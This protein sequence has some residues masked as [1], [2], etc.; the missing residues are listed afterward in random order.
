MHSGSNNFHSSEPIITIGMPVFNGEKTI[1]ESIDSL[2]NQTFLDFKLIISDNVSTDLT[3]KICEDYAKKDKRVQYVKQK[4]NIG[5][6]NNFN[7]LLEKTKS[8]Y[9]MWAASDDFWDT[10]FIK[11]NIQILETKKNMVCSISE[12][13]LFDNFD[14]LKLKRNSPSN[15]LQFRPVQYITG[16]YEEKV[17][18]YL[19][20]NS[21][22]HVYGIFQTEILKKSTVKIEY[23]GWD[24]WILLKA[25]KF[26]DLYVVD[27]VLMY[28]SINGASYNSIFLQYLRSKIGIFNTFFP[29]YPITR[30]CTRNLGITFFLKHI[31]TFAILNGFGELQIIKSIIKLPK[32]YK[33]LFL[34]KFLKIIRNCK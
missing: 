18:S 17:L 21:G 20:F 8:K 23:G 14:D 1:S 15:F 5:M 7:F 26:G 24:L 10:D 4:K 28:R 2:L 33:I 25:L 6:L 16:S 13:V 30:Y 19:K 34:K 9:F 29:Y 31:L 12:I 11:K 27:E 3:Q 32:K 22:S